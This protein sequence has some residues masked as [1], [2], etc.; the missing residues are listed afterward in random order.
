MSTITHD[1]MSLLQSQCIIAVYI[2]LMCVCNPCKFQLK[3]ATELGAVIKSDRKSQTHSLGQVVCCVRLRQEV[4]IILAIWVVH[5][6]LKRYTKTSKFLAQMTFCFK[7]IH[8]YHK[9]KHFFC[10]ERPRKR[11]KNYRIFCLLMNIASEFCKHSPLHL[12]LIS[13]LLLLLLLFLSMA[14]MW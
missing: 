5:H 3:A 11:E 1:S 2:Q 8:Y 6:S 14:C 4:N 9:H 12:V 7:S 13:L 10:I